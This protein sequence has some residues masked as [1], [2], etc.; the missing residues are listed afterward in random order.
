[1]AT[2]LDHVRAAAVRLA[3]PVP[4]TAIGNADAHVAQILAAMQAAADELLDRYP[5]NRTVLGGLWV[6]GRDGRSLA[7]PVADSDA[8]LIDEKLM[9]SAIL[10]RWRSDNGFDYAE[11]FR[12]VEERLARIANERTKAQRGASIS[13]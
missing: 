1:M 7:A 6:R 2:V 9:R 5:V 12:A 8:V 13:L 10:W 11:D 3:L 4:T